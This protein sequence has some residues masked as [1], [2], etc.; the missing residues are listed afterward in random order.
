MSWLNLIKETG[1]GM[2][3]YMILMAKMAYSCGPSSK[4]QSEDSVHRTDTIREEVTWYN[5][6]SGNKTHRIVNI[7]PEDC[8]YTT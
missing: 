7:T 8:P 2:S 5:G 1:M 6:N 3:L 4:V